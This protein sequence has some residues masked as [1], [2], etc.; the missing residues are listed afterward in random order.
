TDFSDR[1]CFTDRQQAYTG[2]R[3][4]RGL[5]GCI[6]SGLNGNQAFGR[7]LFDSG[8]TLVSVLWLFPDHR[9]RAVSGVWDKEPHGHYRTACVYR[10]KQGV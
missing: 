9:L 1:L 6:N 3:T 8:H 5:A 4:I 2:G 10:K 7:L